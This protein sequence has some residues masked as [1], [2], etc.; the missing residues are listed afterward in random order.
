MHID[1]SSVRDSTT[2]TVCIVYHCSI[3]VCTRYIPIY[4]LYPIHRF[5]ILSL[6]LSIKQSIDRWL[7]ILDQVRMLLRDEESSDDSAQH[8]YK[9]ISNCIH[10]KIIGGSKA[11]YITITLSIYTV[12]TPVK[13]V[14]VHDIHIYD[15]CCFY[16]FFYKKK[17][18][19][20]TW[21]GLL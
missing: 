7:C 6:Y 18:R 19:Q 12:S 14:L 13:F 20:D 17:T 5:F 16:D 9:E 10:G 15:F 2:Y 11:L 8:S 3:W 21:H 1:I 4:T